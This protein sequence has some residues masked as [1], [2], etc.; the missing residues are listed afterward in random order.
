[1]ESIAKTPVCNGSNTD[2]LDMILGAG[3]STTQRYLTSILYE[4]KMKLP[5]GSNIEPITLGFLQKP[6]IHIS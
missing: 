1:M 5:N 3:D 6:K 4:F 2:I